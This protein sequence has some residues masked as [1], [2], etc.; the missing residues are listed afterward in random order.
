MC[1]SSD[2]TPRT[3]FLMSTMSFKIEM[4]IDI[5]YSNKKQLDFKN[6][7][8]SH[9]QAF[10]QKRPHETGLLPCTLNEIQKIHKCVSRFC[11]NLSANRVSTFYTIC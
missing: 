4:K 8:T 2:A 10:R 7:Q 6:H 9:K 11:F 5:K 1:I 3:S